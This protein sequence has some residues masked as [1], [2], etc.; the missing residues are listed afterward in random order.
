MKIVKRDYKKERRLKKRLKKEAD[1]EWYL[2][3]IQK[4]PN[5]EVCGKEARQ[6][7]HFYPKGLYGHLRLNKDNGISL[8]MGC[9]F[10]HHHRGDPKIHQAI[11]A[12]RGKKWH[13]KLTKLAYKKS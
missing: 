10:M 2:E 7:H 1:R 13:T 5:C 11:V 3:L 12:A 9:H 8:C 6:V 4:R